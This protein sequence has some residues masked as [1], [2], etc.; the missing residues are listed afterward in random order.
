MREEKQRREEEEAENDPIWEKLTERR[1]LGEIS[2]KENE[3]SDF[4]FPATPPRVPPLKIKLPREVFC[5]EPV[6]A[7]FQCSVRLERIDLSAFGIEM[8]KKVVKKLKTIKKKKKFVTRE[9]LPAEFN[10]SVVLTRIEV[11][12]EETAT[13]MEICETSLLNIVESPGTSLIEEENEAK[14]SCMMI[15]QCSDDEDYGDDEQMEKS[16][17][18]ASPTSFVE[19]QNYF[20]DQEKSSNRIEKK[21]S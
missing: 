2:R 10:C 17:I 8:P 11:P 3:L 5:T 13:A 12:Q 20:V 9:P 21:I 7:R 19:E 16:A 1:P 18:S 4:S 15:V 14:A 6:D